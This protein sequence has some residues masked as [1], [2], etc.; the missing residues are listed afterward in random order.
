MGGADTPCNPFQHPVAILLYRIACR[1]LQD[2]RGFWGYSIIPSYLCNSPYHRIPSYPSYSFT[3][4]TLEP[5]IR[6]PHTLTFEPLIFLPSN[7]SYSYYRTPHT[8][9]LEPLTLTLLPYYLSYP[10]YPLTSYNLIPS[11][12]L[13]CCI[14]FL[15]IDPDVE[16]IRT[17]LTNSLELLRKTDYPHMA[18][19]CGY[20]LAGLPLMLKA[21]LQVFFKKI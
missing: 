10:S 15:M 13:T 21:V 8:L 20:L 16:N 4:R 7:P 12:P 18:A 19:T 17:L 1:M 6:T 9:T 11:Y 5:L 2:T 14:P 3:P